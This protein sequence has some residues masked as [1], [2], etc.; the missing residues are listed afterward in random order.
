MEKCT[1]ALLKHCY[2][3][4]LWW[5]HEELVR[6]PLWLHPVTERQHSLRSWDSQQAFHRVLWWKCWVSHWTEQELLTHPPSCMALLPRAAETCAFIKKA[7]QTF[8]LKT[9]W[10]SFKAANNLIWTEAFSASSPSAKTS[11]R[12]SKASPATTREGSLVVTSSRK[13]P[14]V[15]NKQTEDS[16]GQSQN[17]DDKCANSSHILSSHKRYQGGETFI[18][19][20]MLHA[21]TNTLRTS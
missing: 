17:V 6:R 20:K 4:Q 19:P 16:E 3:T 15:Y 5:R 2:I 11:K 21:A 8:I 9:G 7:I 1:K 14:M 18:G 13:H 10:N 12:A